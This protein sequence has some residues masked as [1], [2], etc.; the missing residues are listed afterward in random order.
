MEYRVTIQLAGEDVPAGTLYTHVRHG[1]ESASFRYDDAYLADRH[2]FPIAPDMPLSA[3]P[4]HTQGEPLFR[5]FGDCM[6][7]RWGRNLM[8]R[9]E[10]RAARE[11]GRTA[12][13]LLEHDMLA[14]VD[15]RARQGAL[16]LWVSGDPV[17]Q[18]GD[19]V[20]REV[21]IPALLAAADRAAHD[22]DADIADLVAAGSSLGGA[23]PKASVVDEHGVLNIAKFPKADELAIED[24]CAWEKTALDLAAQI[25]IRVPQTRL[26]RVGGRSVLLLERFDRRRG[27]RVPYISGL[28]A[29]QG[30]D[31]GRYSYLDLVSFLE[32]EGGAPEAD[33]RELWLRI[34]FSCAI[35]NTDDHMRNHGFLREGAGWR[36]SPAFDVNPTAGDNP[37][38]LRSAIDFDNDEA[39]VEA[40][41]AARRSEGVV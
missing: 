15:D 2:A 38:Y 41:L 11:E 4:L 30:H 32:E 8:L 34:V 23:R 31:G 5:V 33:I 28:T 37:K 7:D 25:G 22:L 40:A 14:S 26:L 36:L 3:A 1:V 6:P 18:E 20:P 21:R 17:A 16:R 19:G 24:V 39:S 29:V 10:R 9:A 27:Q 13:T 12:R 35:G